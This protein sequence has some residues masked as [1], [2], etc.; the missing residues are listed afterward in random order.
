MAFFFLV[1]GWAKDDTRSDFKN[2]L[3]PHKRL[4]AWTDLS[5][6]VKSSEVYGKEESQHVSQLIRTDMSLELWNM[7]ITDLHLLCTLF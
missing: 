2:E 7:M 6:R 3:M 5:L 4:T 1:Q